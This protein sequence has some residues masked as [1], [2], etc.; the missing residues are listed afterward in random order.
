M[1]YAEVLQVIGGEAISVEVE[2]GILKHA[3]VTVARE[4]ICKMV[5]HYKGAEGRQ[6]RLREDEAN[7]VEPL[8]VLGVE[9]HDLLE[10]DMSDRSHT[11]TESC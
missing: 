6:K 8:G 9:L 4:Y 2:Q 7:P 10:K 5:C 3:A 1:T 11:P